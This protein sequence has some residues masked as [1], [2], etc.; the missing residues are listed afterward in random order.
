MATPASLNGACCA[1]AVPAASVD[2]R[3]NPA[4]KFLMNA[5]LLRHRLLTGD[6]WER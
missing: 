3:H 6:R 4:I 2:A 5:S 1:T